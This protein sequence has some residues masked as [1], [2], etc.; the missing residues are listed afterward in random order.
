MRITIVVAENPVAEGMKRV[1][2]HRN[3]RRRGKNRGDISSRAKRKSRSEMKASAAARQAWRSVAP[4]GVAKA[5]HLKNKSKSKLSG[6][7]HGARRR[8]GRGEKGMKAANVV[9]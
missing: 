5:A 7:H 6:G 2:R 8:G 1:A 4:G 3:A 9:R